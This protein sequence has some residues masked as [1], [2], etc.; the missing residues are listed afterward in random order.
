MFFDSGG[1]AKHGTTSRASLRILRNDITLV[2]PETAAPMN[3]EQR[4][5]VKTSMIH[6]GVAMFEV[7]VGPHV[8]MNILAVNMYC[9]YRPTNTQMNGVL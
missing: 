9:I 1:P 8:Y 7:A 4:G 6:V 3:E 5:S 2:V